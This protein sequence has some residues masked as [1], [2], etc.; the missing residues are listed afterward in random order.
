MLL[1]SER[2]APQDGWWGGFMSFPFRLGSGLV[3]GGYTGRSIEYCRY[4]GRGLLPCDREGKLLRACV[5]EWNN[6]AEMGRG[7]SYPCAKEP[8]KARNLRKNRFSGVYFRL[9]TKS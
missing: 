7:S 2:L 3:G 6:H 5:A 1:L 8:E 9:N 4:T